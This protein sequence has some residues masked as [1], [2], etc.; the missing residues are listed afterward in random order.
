MGATK[1]RLVNSE[2]LAQRVADLCGERK[3]L[4]VVVLDV[5]RKSSYADFL[6][7]CSGT[8]DRHVQSIAEFVADTLHKEDRVKTRGSEGMRG[9]QWA[10]LDVGDVILH[11]FHQFTREVYALEDLWGDAPRLPLKAAGH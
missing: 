2:A 11:V 1:E 8:S 3:A 6:V 9:G 4:D 5:R 7:I 10:L